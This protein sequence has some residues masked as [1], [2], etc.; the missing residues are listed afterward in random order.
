MIVPGFIDVHVHGVEGIDVLDD[1]PVPWRRVAADLPKYGVTAFCPTSVACAP[2][3]LA[4]LL[5]AVAAARSRAAPRSARVL[6]AHLES[7]FINPEW[8]GAQPSDCLRIC[9]VHMVHTA[10]RPARRIHRRRHP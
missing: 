10:S 7:N 5:A 9:H 8:N 3:R 1:E 2:A 4:T 6:P